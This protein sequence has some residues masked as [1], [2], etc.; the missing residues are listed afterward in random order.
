MRNVFR[1]IALLL[2][3]GL[4]AGC[5]VPFGAA[6]RELSQAEGDGAYLSI[7]DSEP[8]TADPQCTTGYYTIPLNVFNRLV[9]SETASGGSVIVPSLADSWTISQDGLTY[10]FH[11]REGVKFSNGSDLTASDVDYTLTRLLTWPE[12]M[13]GDPVTCIAGAEALHTGKADTL[14]GFHLIDDYNFSITLEQPYAPFL[15]CLST[16]GVSILDRET[17]EAAGDRF[18]IDPAQTVGT[19]PFL[20]QSW[21]PGAGILLEANPDCWEGPPKCAGVSIRFVSDPE[22]QRVMYENGELDIL[23][24]DNLGSEA[25]YYLHGDIYQ[26]QLRHGP[27]VGITYIALNQSVPPLDDLR[28]RKA[29]Q[30]ALDRETLMNAVISGRGNVEQGILPHGLIGYN[31]KLAEIPYDPDQ[32][33]ALLAEAGYPDGLDLVVTLPDTTSKSSREQASLLAAMWSKSGI[34]ATI[35]YVAEPEFYDLRKAGSLSCYISTWS[36]DYND[37]DNFIYTFFGNRENTDARSL[38]YPDEEIMSRVRQARYIVDT[39]ERLQE[40]QALERIIVQDNAAWIPLYSREHYF[41]VSR[42]ISGFQLSWN[43]WSSSCYKNVSVTP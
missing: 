7:A 9:E 32:A 5:S 30:L 26:P 6:E 8:D 12:A 33:Q 39:A 17:T 41:A 4:L 28:V 42:R 15:A 3:L 16:P 43:G 20:F 10:T 31:P 24:M 18:G 19:G 36:A 1:W 29:L 2:S 34:R 25:E 35:R 11:L 37:P 22:A 23:D 40:Y 13:N 38:C 14:S 21:E 27:R